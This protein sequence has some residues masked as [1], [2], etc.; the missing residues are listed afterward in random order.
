M[1]QFC[2]SVQIVDKL[3]FAKFTYYWYM[4]VSELVKFSSYK[5]DFLF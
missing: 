5:A 4:E 1:L 2:K 3:Y